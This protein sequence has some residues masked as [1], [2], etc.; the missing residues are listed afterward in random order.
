[1]VTISGKA[2]SVEFTNVP[3]GY[4]TGAGLMVRD[5]TKP[6]VLFAICGPLFLAIGGSPAWP[7]GQAGSSERYP[8]AIWEQ[9]DGS[10]AAGW[11]EAGLAAARQYSADI[12]SAAVVIVQGG[13]IVAEW[14]AV[15]QKFGSHSMRKSLL[16]AL[17]GPYVAEGKISL[18]KT[19]A[20]LGIEDNEPALTDLEK[21][22]TIFDL[23]RARSGIYHPGAVR[24]AEHE[25]GKAGAAQSCAR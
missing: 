3:S 6:L 24:S 9:I 12:Q 25:G 7:D 13:M 2:N 14:G 5:L 10:A 19:I 4:L 15:D 11:S 22:A 17:Y 1:M 21:S 23:L 16:S 18:S 20:E 8:G